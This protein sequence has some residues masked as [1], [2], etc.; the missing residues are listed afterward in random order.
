MNA[1]LNLGMRTLAGLA[2][3]AA[4]VSAA[5]AQ[6]GRTPVDLAL[7]LSVDISGSMDEDEQDIQRQGYV[8]AFKHSAVVNAIHNGGS[9]GRIAVAYLEWSE[10]A[11]VVVDW[12]I[13]S[14]AKDAT[15]FAEK[16]RSEPLNRG[17]RTSISLGLSAAKDLLDNAPVSPGRRVIDISGDGANNSGEPV[18]AVRDR[19]VAE[20]IIINGLPLTLR[21]PRPN[22]PQDMAA[23]YRDCVKGGRGSFVLG[24]K[25]LAEMSGTIRNKLITEIADL[26]PRESMVIPAQA[27]IAPPPKTDCNN[28]SG[29]FGGRGFYNFNT[30]PF[31]APPAN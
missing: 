11:A 31:N 24:I 23:Y 3:A 6:T 14:N 15:A 1:G 18:E 20:G 19:L 2:C 10:D 25:S 4:L 9:T 30:Q 17:R 29:G 8:D 21:P 12:T 26:A 27:S 22:D 5:P 28:R 16:L 13:I 7:V